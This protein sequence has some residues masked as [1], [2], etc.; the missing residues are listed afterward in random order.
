MKVPGK[1]P[2]VSAMAKMVDKSILSPSSLQS[3]GLM[4]HV[5]DEEA[6]RAM[7]AGGRGRTPEAPH[8][9]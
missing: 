4:S 9:G 3:P 2:P 1:E 5:A 6:A 7:G 8:H